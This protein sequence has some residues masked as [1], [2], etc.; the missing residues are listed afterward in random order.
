L[1]DHSHAGACIPIDNG[2]NRP[3]S[4]SELALPPTQDYVLGEEGL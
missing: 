3:G 1:R 2:M 4:V